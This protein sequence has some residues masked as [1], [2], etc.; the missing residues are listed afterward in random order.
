MDNRSAN[1][2]TTWQTS[3]LAAS[4]LNYDCK[5]EV[6][7]RILEELYEYQNYFER[8][9]CDISIL[10]AFVRNMRGFQLQYNITFAGDEIG[11]AAA[12]T[13]EYLSKIEI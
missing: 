1:L 6:F 13:L 11:E 10:G 8:N 9:I 12:K 4:K 7:K 2:I 3:L 5:K